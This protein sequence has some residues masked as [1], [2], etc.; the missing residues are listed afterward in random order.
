MSAPQGTK[1]PG[2]MKSASSPSPQVPGHEPIVP[3]GPGSSTRRLWTCQIWRLPSATAPGYSEFTPTCPVHE[4]PV[5]LT[6]GVA[7]QV[8]G[9]ARS[10]SCTVAPSAAG[11]P[12]LRSE[13]RSVAFITRFPA[14]S[15]RGPSGQAAF[16]PR[17]RTSL[18]VNLTR[19]FS[20]EVETTTNFTWLFEDAA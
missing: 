17:H 9:I 5:V 11:L 7:T 6:V 12:L 18:I 1:T 16:V 8:T 14:K 19:A 20:G 3:F 13:M 4:P 15:E 10:K 2:R